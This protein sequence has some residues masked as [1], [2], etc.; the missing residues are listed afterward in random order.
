MGRMRG[1]QGHGQ[2]RASERRT[3][4]H[5]GIS[6]QNTGQEREAEGKKGVIFGREDTALM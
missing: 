6:K 4:D 2:L 3:E 1:Q 5:V